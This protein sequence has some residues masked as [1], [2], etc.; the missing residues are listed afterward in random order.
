MASIL[1]LP[2]RP[3]TAYLPAF[4][5]KPPFRLTPLFATLPTFPSFPFLPPNNVLNTF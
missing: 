3:T 5:K 4:L 1:L 2:A